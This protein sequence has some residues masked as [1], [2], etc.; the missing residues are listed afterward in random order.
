MDRADEDH[1]VKGTL[2]VARHARITARLQDEVARL[3]ARLADLP[4]PTADLG[5]LLDPELSLPAFEASSVHEKRELLRLAIERV[6]VT[7]APKRGA[8]FVPTERMSVKWADVA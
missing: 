5:G 7:A 8:R 4:E 2:D 1:Y 3:V 6:E